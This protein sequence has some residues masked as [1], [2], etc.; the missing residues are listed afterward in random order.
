MSEPHIFYPH[1]RDIGPAR[2]KFPR[3]LA[4]NRDAGIVV[5]REYRNL[6]ASLS[7]QEKART[8][9]E[10]RCDVHGEAS[11]PEWEALVRLFNF[12]VI[13]SLLVAAGQAHAE[14]DPS[15]EIR[16]LQA[17][18]KQLEQRVDDQARKER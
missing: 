14:D 10:A 9:L 15:A 12:I 13:G 18:L 16:A 6:S 8:H 2:K 11:S 4:E 7:S 3:R 5:R 17:K 1:A